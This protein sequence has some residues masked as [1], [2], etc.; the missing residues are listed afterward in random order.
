MIDIHNIQTATGQCT[1]KIPFLSDIENAEF[2]SIGYSGLTTDGKRI[3][4]SEFLN[5]L[6][7]GEFKV[8]Q[9]KFD[10]GD[11]IEEFIIVRAY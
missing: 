7:K 3:T 5:S 4:R 9:T 11:F 8:Q 2:D 10:N 1:K 6:G